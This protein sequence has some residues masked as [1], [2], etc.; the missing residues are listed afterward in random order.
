MDGPTPW[1]EHRL[2]PDLIE[3]L[4]EYGFV[5]VGPARAQSRTSDSQIRRNQPRIG[6]RKSE[7]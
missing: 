4:Q 7:A 1:A 5:V 3:A 6:L 2:A